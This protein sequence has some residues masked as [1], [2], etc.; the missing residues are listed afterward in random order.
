MA[1]DFAHGSGT[2]SDPYLIAT[3]ADFWGIFDVSSGG[4]ENFVGKHF[5]QTADIE[6]TQSI[7]PQTL[8]CCVYDG[9]NHTISGLKKGASYLGSSI[10][11]NSI[12]S[13]CTNENPSDYIPALFKW[14]WQEDD[15]EGN[16]GPKSELHY[17]RLLNSPGIY[18]FAG[19]DTIATNLTV[20]N[21]GGFVG[22]TLEDCEISE[23][24]GENLSHTQEYYAT[25]ALCD[26]FNCKFENM[27]VVNVEY[28][29]TKWSA[30]GMVGEVYYSNFKN[31]VV[32]GA[33]ITAGTSAGGFA[34]AVYGGTFEDCYALGVKVTLEPYGPY[35]NKSGGFVGEAYTR[36]YFGDPKYIPFV[37]RRCIA[38]GDVTCDAPYGS[39]GFVGHTWPD[40]GAIFDQCG[41]EV[42]VDNLSKSSGGFVGEAWGP[43]EPVIVCKDC[44]A[45]GNSIL[46][47]PEEAES[48]GGF[49]GIAEDVLFEKC[50]SNGA[51]SG[52][53]NVGGFCGEDAGY[54]SDGE[55]HWS[56]QCIDCYY[57]SETSG[58]S[59]TGKG[60][61]KTTAEMKTQSTFFGWNFVNTWKLGAF[62]GGNRKSIT[63]ED[64]EYSV[65]VKD[66][67]IDVFLELD[68]SGGYPFLQFE[69]KK[70]ITKSGRTKCDWYVRGRM[71]E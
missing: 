55:E 38:H 46:S 18:I 1:Y 67:S 27:V 45:I 52:G 57:D 20:K 13:N 30:G 5:H 59:D 56:I 23:C 42:S 69:T 24:Y 6:I 54:Y 25:G 49:C 65:P 17:I 63:N 12:F 62:A 16:L 2:K 64:G 50:F 61:P 21:S 58:Q 3:E 44:Y 14:T 39:G 53:V 33:M 51:V 19:E 35:D 41:A 8:I 29:G 34:G 31:C 15:G 47:N 68:P 66:G 9:E 40:V 32:L 71:P 37:F 10:W 7:D 26:V 36:R 43:P 48:N 28:K 22:S 70:R 11:K 4:Q 60:T